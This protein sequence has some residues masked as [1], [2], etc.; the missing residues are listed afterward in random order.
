MDPDLIRRAPRDRCSVAH[1][2]AVL[3]E[4]WTILVLR[5]AF[6]G[7]RRFDE[8]QRAIGCARNVLADRLA[9][10][11]E[12]GVLARVGYRDEGQRERF[13]YRLTPMGFEA[14]PVIVALMQWGDRWL[15]APG[16]P[17]IEV[18]H[19]G[20]GAKVHAELRCE[21]AHGA[22]T[23]RDTEPRPLGKVAAPKR[24]AARS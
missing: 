13:E 11:V 23:A 15:P 9:T 21:Q 10:L 12:H 7:I 24:K 14:F 20:C 17:P 4:R 16:G 6:Y 22:L 2:L 8:M 3:G 19:R 18:V 1:A 5:E